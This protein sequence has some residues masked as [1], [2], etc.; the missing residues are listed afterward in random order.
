MFAHVI[1]KTAAPDLFQGL[2]DHR[3]SE[4]NDGDSKACRDPA[5]SAAIVEFLRYDTQRL[6][7]EECAVRSDTA[8]SCSFPEWIA[9]CSNNEICS[10]TCL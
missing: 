3:T 2:S 1:S 8:C 5:P 4:L 7:L 9:C 6:E 10:K